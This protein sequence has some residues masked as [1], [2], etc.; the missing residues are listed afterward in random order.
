MSSTSRPDGVETTPPELTELEG[1]L[2]AYAV[3]TISDSCDTTEIADRLGELGAPRGL[4][5]SIRR[6]AGRW[7]VSDDDRID[8]IVGYAATRCR[9][10]H[11]VADAHADRLRDVGLTELDIVDLDNIVAY[12]R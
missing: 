12:Y 11:G 7:P 2:A 5:E 10:A 9:A 1:L 6:A 8:V 3:S 4:L